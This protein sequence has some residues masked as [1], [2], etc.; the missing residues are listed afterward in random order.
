MAG[1]TMRVIY[2]DQTETQPDDTAGETVK[3]KTRAEETQPDVD[4]FIVE[5][6]DAEGTPVYKDT[7][8]NLRAET[9]ETDGKME[10]PWAATRWRSGSGGA[11]LETRRLGTSRLFRNA[12]FRNRK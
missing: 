4:Q 7:Y 2:D 10:L 5:I 8:A 6:T 11:L 9:D 1:M 12:R 3:P